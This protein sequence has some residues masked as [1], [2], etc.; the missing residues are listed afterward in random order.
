[1]NRH[2][3][4]VAT[5]FLLSFTLGI[6]EVSY[7][8]FKWMDETLHV[9]AATNYWINGQFEPDIWEHPP[10]RHLLLQ[11]FLE[12]FGDNP[13]GWRMRNV[14][15]GALGATLTYLFAHEI[16]GRK[17]AALLAGILIATDPLHVVLSRFTF[18][19]IYGG[20]FFLAAIILYLRHRQRCSL[21]VF[22]AFSLG[23]AVA[24][25]WA[26]LPGWGL[27]VTLAII[28]TVRSRKS[29]ALPFIV[30]AY[31]L[32]PISV[33]IC[34]YYPWLGR[35]YTL[36]EML[37][38]VINAYN[39]LQKLQAGSYDYGLFFLKHISAA[40]WFVSPIMVGQ[41]TYAGVGVGRGEFILYFNNLP[42]WILTIPSMV[43]MTV[44]SL[45]EKNSQLVIP[46][47]FF[48]VSYALFFFVRRPAFI[49]SATPLL[50]FAFTAI[51]TCITR[52]SDRSRPWIYGTVLTIILTWNL[53]LYPL[54][55][56][57]KVPVA[58]YRYLL[59]H[60][61]IKQSR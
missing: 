3:I 21:I 52:I 30:S 38:L 20:V 13:Y 53:Y 34:A 5:I 29:V 16:T 39:S 58:A 47:L 26:Y 55:T 44:L 14:L 46:V 36:G 4:L 2:A 15:F 18:D 28:E 11:L 32:I 42:I 61:D 56:A 8:S 33:Y 31:I 40:E 35:G 23:C 60:A 19:E 9:Q 27:L 37:E 50:P 24:I 43:G 17:K 59:E 49:Y 48:C 7:P 45:R 10:L 41:G 25:K 57:K 54:V 1:M 12:I 22:S 6:Y 51:A